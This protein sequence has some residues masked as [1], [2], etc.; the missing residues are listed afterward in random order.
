[1]GRP[2]RQNKEQ[3]IPITTGFAQRRVENDDKAVEN[4]YLAGGP[5]L[6]GTETAG[7]GDD[8]HGSRQSTALNMYV[9]HGRSLNASSKPKP[10]A[11][12]RSVLLAPS[13]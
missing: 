5:R 13:S 1:M 6:A 10:P 3:A 11:L 8:A 2:E 12:M 9:S 7:G 4:G